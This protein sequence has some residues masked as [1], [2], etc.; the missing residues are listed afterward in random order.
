MERQTQTAIESSSRRSAV[1]AVLC[2][3]IS[4]GQKIAKSYYCTVGCISGTPVL[5]LLQQ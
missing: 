2:H 1:T 5:A 4:V 3:A